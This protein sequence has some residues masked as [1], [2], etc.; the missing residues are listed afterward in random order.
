MK[1]PLPYPFF[2]Q[3]RYLKWKTFTMLSF[4]LFASGFTA[5]AQAVFSSVECFCLDN[6]I[7]SSN[8]Q[9]RD[10]IIVVTGITGQTWRV[11]SPVGFYNMLSPAPPLAPILLLNN[12]IIPEVSPGRY[13]LAGKRVSGLPWTVTVT[14]GIETLTRSSVQSCSYPSVAA[15]TISGDAFV[16]ISSAENYSIPANVLLSNINWTV[17]GGVVSAG[18]GTNSI[19]VTWGASSG[20]QTLSVTGELASYAGQPNACEF[21]SQRT[22]SITNVVPPTTIAGDFGNCIGASEVYTIP[23]AVNLLT[24]VVWTVLESDM[25][26]VAPITATGSA[27]SRT[28][29]WPNTPGVYYIRV[30]GSYR[31][32]T[33]TTDYCPFTSI[34]RV[35][36]VNELTVAMA[37][38]NLVNMSMNPDC[39][40][41]FLA[42]HFLE[43]P[44][45]PNSSYDIVITDLETG[46]VIPTGTLGYNYINKTL[47]IQVVHECSGNSCWGYAKIEDKSIPE[48]ICP[49]DITIDCEDLS[50]LS[51]TGYPVTGPGV[52]R[53]ALSNGTFL[54]QNFD[55]CSDVILS[56]TDQSVTGLCDG[57]YSAIITRMWRAVDTYNNVSTCTQT[58]YVNRATLADLVMPGSW[59]NVLG[60]N[61]SLE[62]CDNYPKL[63]E[64][65]SFEG[66]PDPV[67]T[68]MP[69]GIA[70]LK[71]HVEFTDIR[72]PICGENSYKIR[73][74][75]R[76]IDHCNPSLSD[77]IYNQ[78]ITVMDT[79]GPVVTCP[80]DLVNQNDPDN[81]QLAAVI[82]AGQ[83]SC[84]AEWSVLPPTVIFECS[85]VT[86][87]VEFL[88]ADSNGLPPANGVYV[89]Q[90]GS[91]RVVGNRPAFRYGIDANARPFRIENLP[92]GRT[93]IRYTIIDEC[94]NF[95]YCFTEI[96]VVDLVPPTPVCDRTSNIAIAADGMGWAGVQTFND[97]SHDNCAL[98]YLKVRR[99]SAN[100]VAWSE[101]ERNN[102]VKFSCDD[103]G[104]EVMVELGVWDKAGNFN[105][106]MVNARVQDNIPPTVIPPADRTA[107]CNE[108][109]TNLSRFGM[110]T[111]TD[112]CTFTLVIDSTDNRGECGTGAIVRRFTATDKHGNV[113]TRTQNINVINNR[114]FRSV[115]S[116]IV[117]PQNALNFQGCTTTPP[118]P[119]A[120]PLGQRRP[121]LANIACSQV[122]ATYEDIIFQ[123]TEEA[124]LKVLR[125]WTVIDW[126]QRNPFVEGSGTWTHTQVIMINNT[127]GNFRPN[128]TF[129][130][131]PSHLTITQV[132][133][134]Q[135]RVQVTGTATDDCTP[136]DKLRWSFSID[137]GNNGTIDFTGNTR[138]IDRVLNYGTHRIIWT[139]RDECNN[140][141]T[142]TNTFTIVDDK[143]PTP[144]CITELVT[145]IMPTSRN[146]TIWAS[147]FDLGATDN[148][149]TGTQLRASF[150]TNVNDISRT[151]T[152]AMMT[153]PATEFPL[154]VYITDAQGNNDFCTVR[155]R[156]Q[157][158]VNACGNG[159]DDNNPPQEQ[160][161]ILRGSIYTDNDDMVSDVEVQ[162]NS[163][164]PE[165]PKAVKSS[166]DGKFTFD[167]LE[168]YKDYSITPRFDENPL[169]GVSTLDLVLI[170]R[171][172]LGIQSLDSPYKL[173]AADVNNSQRITAADLVDLRKVILGV[174]T[175]FPNNTSWRFVDVAHLFAD[176]SNPFPFT[177][178]VDMQELDHNVAGLDFIAVKVG[179]VNN[180]AKVNDATD[181]ILGFRSTK[182]LNVNHVSGKS[183]DKVYV[184]LTTDDIR[185]L[186]GLQMGLMFDQ[187]IAELIDIQSGSLKL[188]EDHISYNELQSGIIKFSWN[189]DQPADFTG[190]LMTMVFRLNKDVEKAYIIDLANHALQ[191]EVYTIEQNTVTSAA[192]N[193]RRGAGS[194]EEDTRF[195]LYQNI[196]NPFN[197]GTMIGF[198]L[199]EAGNVTLKVYDIEGKIRHQI[200]GKYNK[201][202]NTIHLEREMLNVTGIMYYQL[203]TDT[204][205]A[206]RKM[207]V[208][209]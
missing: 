152:C 32:N 14:N 39:E 115:A 45:Y 33:S 74:R 67:Y 174:N 101:L 142:C 69:T 107:N 31:P 18:Q 198:S 88:L 196:P 180:T 26:T 30:T 1:R 155:L 44:A 83:Y 156:V 54:L 182:S 139:V 108:D 170:Q 8:G 102:T 126:C 64:G 204:H 114:P 85:R 71:A 96:D 15:T 205:S 29:Q 46:L 11:Q 41:N 123:Y 206:T 208:I 34:Q 63:P 24:G 138:S 193:L 189:A 62:A 49:D 194:M 98:D 179:D 12:T 66:N 147:D 5:N 53:T 17:T 122:A 110:P 141:G 77:T 87:D 151:I 162:L 149:S 106:C 92:S 207:I 144:Y 47:K 187:K 146:V 36:I 105:S 73:R 192:L 43:D 35:D 197:S 150:S 137:E 103:I 89:K 75:W 157:D 61:P 113:T 10:S 51:V 136:A 200:S 188:K 173:I 40:L 93:W 124:C 86:W 42:D 2:N 50:N 38:N 178:K 163:N 23:A 132:G 84:G 65:H 201:G 185:Q 171:H 6:A 58:I 129:G 90:S 166:V 125:K 154:N 112:N 81:I 176:P 158:N 52:V 95:S 140:V 186:A 134:C 57:P 181:N 135:A 37:C 130:C 164:L 172:V 190:E 169:N 59:D 3:I 22:I 128:I 177:E 175:T 76:V 20:P 48:L 109:F 55:R 143:K 111:V 118:L 119:D 117:W 13:A 91:T 7:T 145:V 184:Q 160:R 80:A 70:C 116:D 79:K 97:G 148:C 82:S 19:T 104:T 209:K 78:F 203:D 21:S 199:P 56:F 167:N 131:Q 9:Y 183:G 60:P 100:P 94:E 68:G 165:F 195:E 168:M 121:T 191:S 27:N 28:I 120:L 99:M 133:T 25:S 153:G 202:Y 16:C 159:V 161:V 72:I 127:T 4:V